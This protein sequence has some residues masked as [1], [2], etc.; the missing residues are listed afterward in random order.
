MYHFNGQNMFISL[1]DTP[2]VIVLRTNLKLLSLIKSLYEAYKFT[3]KTS[4]F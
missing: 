3:L 4:L 1:T 2:E